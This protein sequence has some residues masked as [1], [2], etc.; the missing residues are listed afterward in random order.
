[1]LV[2]GGYVR[3]TSNTMFEEKKFHQGFLVFGTDST[4]LN[5]CVAVVNPVQLKP[6]TMSLAGLAWQI[7]TENSTANDSNLTFMLFFFYFFFLW[8]EES[9]KPH[10]LLWQSCAFENN[11]FDRQLGCVYIVCIYISSAKMGCSEPNRQKIQER[12]YEVR[13]IRNICQLATQSTLRDR[14][15]CHTSICLR[16]S[17]SVT[18]R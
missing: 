18:K 7:E 10:F 3:E 14:Q 6:I 12:G 4:L 2:T 5:I 15:Q 16:L 1:M 13:K 17:E 11:W 8:C 9:E